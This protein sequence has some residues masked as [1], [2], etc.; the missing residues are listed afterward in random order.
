MT[1]NNQDRTQSEGQGGIDRETEDRNRENET[2]ES[3]GQTSGENATG[4][5]G[6]QGSE[7][8]VGSGNDNSSDYLTKSEQDQDLAAEGQGT[9]ET[10]AGR[11]DVETGQSS[12]RESEHDG[13][14]GK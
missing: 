5:T 1:D 2:G 13:S 4:E 9:Q 7:G 11:S 14:I 6:S 10:S 3:K 12:D 8:F